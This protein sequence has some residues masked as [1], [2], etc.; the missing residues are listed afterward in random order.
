MSEKSLKYRQYLEK[1]EDCPS[2]DF[3]EV[4]RPAYRWVKGVA[5]SADFVPVNIER[6]PPPRML[7]DADKMCMAYG[8]SMFDSWANSMAK[9]EKEYARR[10]PHQRAQFV[11]DKGGFIACVQLTRDDGLADEPNPKNHG[12]FTFHEY[13]RARLVQNVLNVQRIFDDN[14]EFELHR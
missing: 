10:R 6:E 14:G 8:L 13:E 5:T 2:S 11:E 7:D 3:V 9:F 12:H 4:D 1:F